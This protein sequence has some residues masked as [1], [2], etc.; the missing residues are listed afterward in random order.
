[1]CPEVHRCPIPS[2]CSSLPARSR[3]RRSDRRAATPTSRWRGITHRPTIRASCTS[4]AA[5]SRRC[6]RCRSPEHTSCARAIASICSPRTISATSSCCGASPM[7]ISSATGWSS[8]R[9][10]AFT[11]R[12]R[13]RPVRLACRDT[14][15]IGS[16]KLSLLMGPVP[17]PAPRAVVDA[18]SAVK[19]ELGS[20]DAQGGFELTFDVPPRS[21]LSTLFLIS[22]GGG[23]VPLMRVILIVTLGGRAEPIVDGVATNVEMQP[24]D[25]GVGKVVVKGKDLSALMDV[26]ELPATPFPAMPPSTRV[27]L[28]L[29]KYAAFGVVPKVIPSLVEDVPLPTEQI[30]QQQGTD[31]AYVKKLAQDAGYVF[32]L[33]PGPVP[34]ISTAYWGPEI[35]VGVPQPALTTGMNA[36]TNVE[37]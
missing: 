35:R 12:F 19:V 37:Q 6:A 34:G 3:R 20:G 21:P 36:L 1:M 33:E 17:I 25:G 16:L 15:M 32:Y 24:G 28:I 26:E 27:L 5:S 9:S 31:Y 10:Q 2:R 8:P 23:G 18:L 7:P 4:F 14:T 30:P 22:G 11:S 29:A 13:C